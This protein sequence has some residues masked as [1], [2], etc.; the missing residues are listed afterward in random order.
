MKKA[1]KSFSPV[2]HTHDVQKI[3][4]GK[5]EPFTDEEDAQ[6]SQYKDALRLLKEKIEYR[7]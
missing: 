5:C 3:F 2:I 4:I 7:M 1:I 6:L